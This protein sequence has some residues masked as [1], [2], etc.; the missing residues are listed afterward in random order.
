M[1][2]LL[3]AECSNLHAT[4][5]RGLRALGH[6]V[7]VVSSGNGWRN[8]PRDISII[9]RSNAPLDSAA[10][11]LRLVGLLPRLRGWD[12]VQIT[13]PVFLDLCPQRV[14]WFYDYLL[15]HNRHVV[16]GAFGTDTYWVRTCMEQKPLR[17]SDHNI[18]AR[19]RTDAAALQDQR[20]WLGTPRETLT[21]HVVQTCHAIAAC[22][23]EYYAVYQLVCPEKTAYV[24]LPVDPD[25]L[26][27][28]RPEADGRVKFFIGIDASRHQYKGTDIMLRALEDVCRRYP[29]RTAM[30]KAVSVPFAQYEQM[31]DGSDVLLDQ[32]YSY[33]PSM[34]TLTAMAKGLVCVGGGEEE[35]YAVLH[36]D[37]LRPIINVC[38]SYDSVRDALEHLVLHPEL[39]PRLKADSMEYVRRHHHYV[40]VARQYADLYARLLRD[41]SA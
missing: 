27:K 18:G 9:R 35:H 8:Y 19:V 11:L 20:E 3:L 30:R 23:Y 33:T 4:L 2:I 17:Y 15:R 29:D 5:A 24:P 10:Y 6:E 14:R 32:L 1:R 37:T 21:R 13:N 28:A 26:R 12:I 39:L 7:L 40:K 34:N 38:P 25:A 41:G 16:L 22:L 36:E 31:M